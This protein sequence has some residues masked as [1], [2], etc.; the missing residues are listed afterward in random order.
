LVVIATWSLLIGGSRI[1][2]A[3]S[4]GK[5]MTGAWTIAL[6]G[7]LLVLLGVLLVVSPG[8]GAVGITWAIGWFAF[9]FGTV[10]LWVA[11]A[12]RHESHELTRSPGFRASQPGHAV[13]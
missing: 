6:G 1:A 4:A 2:F 8:A 12:V 9:L 5:H 13:G 7:V 10:E 3:I 11:F